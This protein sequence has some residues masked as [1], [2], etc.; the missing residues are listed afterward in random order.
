MIV[1]LLLIRQKQK[2]M[3][4][5]IKEVEDSKYYLILIELYLDCYVFTQICLDILQIKRVW[6]SCKKK[7][8]YYLSSSWY[9]FCTHIYLK[10]KSFNSLLYFWEKI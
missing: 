7:S 10:K 9:N 1:Q 2:K 8:Y 3:A 5:D 4:A 6:S